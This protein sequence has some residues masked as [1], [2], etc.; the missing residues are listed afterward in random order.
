MQQGDFIAIFNVRT[1]G[2]SKFKI[3]AKVVEISEVVEIFFV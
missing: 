3:K 2:S 1:Y